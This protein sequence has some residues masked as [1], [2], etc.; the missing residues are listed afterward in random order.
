[1]IG[2][3]KYMFYDVINLSKYIITKCVKKNTPITNMQL[4]QILY[5]IQ[6]VF[7]KK[8]EYAFIDNIEAWTFGPVV[9]RAYYRFCGNGVM[10]ITWTYDISTI[11]EEDTLL[12]DRIIDRYRTISPY[13][14]LN[15]SYGKESAW[16]QTYNQ[17]RGNRRS[18]PSALIKSEG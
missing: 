15:K 1:M 6:K 13:D 14:I 9:P 17:G 10:P 5:Q 2:I 16:Q 3:S 18:I 12:I 11:Q 7:L 4:Q 8:D